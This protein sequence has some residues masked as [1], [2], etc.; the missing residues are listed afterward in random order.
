MTKASFTNGVIA[1]FNLYLNHIA[2]YFTILAYALLYN[3]FNAEQVFV[4]ISYYNILKLSLTLSFGYGISSVAALKV[5]LK[6]LNDFLVIEEYQEL[7]GSD[8]ENFDP[9]ASQNSVTLTDGTVRWTPSSTKNT[10]TNVTFKVK[11]NNLVAVVGEVGSGKSSLLYTI[12]REL[13]LSSGVL[14]V[15]GTISYASQESWIFPTTVRQNILFGQPMDRSRYKKVIKCC[16]LKRDIDLFPHG[17]KTIIG[18]RGITL[19]GGQR[20]RIN[21][22]RTVYKDA[23]IYLLDDPLSAVDTRVG[24]QLFEECIRTFLK[25][26]TVILVTHQ[27]QYLKDVDNIVVLDAGMVKKEGNFS[28]LLESSQEFEALLLEAEKQKSNVDDA[29]EQ[30][31]QRALLVKS[32]SSLEESV[33][34]P[35]EVPEQL[36]TGSVSNYLYRAYFTSGSNCCLLS[37]NAMLFIT[38]AVAPSLCTYFLTYW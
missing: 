35:E 7:Y 20:A 38:A 2:L 17:D 13:P 25:D 32:V 18:E 19:S 9:S 36:S 29:V 16:A 28:T 34:A 24:K 21:L 6:R 23:D 37:Y 4:L 1:A 11:Q 8:L 31:T 26:K 14:T 12:L 10:L 22:A 5:S 15:N 33:K 27:L 3:D 30:Q